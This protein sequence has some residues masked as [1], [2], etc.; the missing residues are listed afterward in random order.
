[1]LFSSF[2]LFLLL[3]DKNRGP[4]QKVKASQPKTTKD[5]PREKDNTQLPEISRQGTWVKETSKE[6]QDDN[7]V[8]KERNADNVEEVNFITV[9]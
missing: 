6:V 9:Y 4:I 7:K 2:L 5:S 1:M 3:I 8:S